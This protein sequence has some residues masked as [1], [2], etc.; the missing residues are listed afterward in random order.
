MLPKENRL[1]RKKDFSLVFKYGARLKSGY[2]EVRI[3]E[4]KISILRIGFIVSKT[5]FKAAVERNRVKRQLRNALRLKLPTLKNGYD[6]VVI[7]RAEIKKKSF[8][9]ISQEMDKLLAKI[10]TVSK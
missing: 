8:A 1:T 4:N 7:A 2:L 5:S 3:V 10:T 9:Q 6:L